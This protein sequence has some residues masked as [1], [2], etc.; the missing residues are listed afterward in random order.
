MKWYYKEFE[1]TGRTI[2]QD[3]SGEIFISQWNCSHKVPYVPVTTEQLKDL[4]VLA[5]SKT[6]ADLR[7]TAGAACWLAKSSRPD[8]AFE[9]SLVQQSINQASME[10]VKLANQLVRRARL[11]KYEVKI[12]TV[13]ISDASSGKMPRGGSQGGFCILVTNELVEHESTPVALVQWQ[14]HRLKR[15]AEVL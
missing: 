4:A 7:K 13:V 5:D 9:V 14:S 11:I 6:V 8:L 1:Y 2:R 15:V 12:P 10:T 3:D